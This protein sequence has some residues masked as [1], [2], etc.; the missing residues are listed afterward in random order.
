MPLKIRTKESIIENILNDYATQYGVDVSEL[1]DEV[2]VRATVMGGAIW[3]LELKL[4]KVQNNLYPDKSEEN[5]LI[6]DGLIWLGREPSAGEQ[7]Q[8]ECIISGNGGGVIPASTQF[9]SDSTS[10]SPNY[11]FILDTDFTMP[12][13]VGV[14]T[15]GT[16]TLR[17]LT[18][19][20]DAQLLV[21]D[22]LT[23][24]QPLLDFD[25]SIEVDS[26]TINPVAPEDLESYRADVLETK[27]IVA[28]GGSPSDY[29]KWCS[30]VPTIRT[31][32]PYLQTTGGGN[33]IVYVEATKENTAVNQVTGVPTQD[34]LDAVY[35]WD[36]ITETGAVIISPE[37]TGRRPVGVKNVV[38]VSIQ[39]IP[40][41][42]YF[43]D[44]TDNEK[45]PTIK[46]AVDEHLYE[47]R[48]FVAG[49]D[50]I[51]ARNDVVSGGGILSAI[52]E[53]LLGSGATFSALSIDYNGQ[54]MAGS[55]RV[56]W[57]NIP[58]LRNVYNNGGLI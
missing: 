17:S 56:L 27:R 21:A 12:G 47:I 9:K 29:R 11:L 22:T 31:V 18:V 41:D 34:T 30:E 38:S 25:D 14:S 28:Q 5:E 50:A 51:G 13:S 10:T 53:S 35:K 54:E 39:P 3:T 42:L 46:T 33:N 58:Y 26:I 45:S 40:V 24:I 48:P 19:G 16:I 36:G 44:L 15:T 23:S 57:G 2:R 49:A 4:S 8:Y 43:T 20:L 6:R 55:E 52:Y 1:G 7:G 37:L 32:Y